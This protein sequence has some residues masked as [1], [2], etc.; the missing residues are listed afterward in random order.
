M[1]LGFATATEAAAFGVI[2]A[3]ILAAVQGSLTLRQLHRKPDGRDAH[4]LR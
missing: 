1:Y 2:G 3:L 4:V